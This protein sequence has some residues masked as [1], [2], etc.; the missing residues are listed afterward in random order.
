MQL[1]WVFHRK[2]FQ[3]HCVD[4]RKDDGVGTNADRKGQNRND[5]KCRTLSEL[6]A[7]IPQ[8]AANVPEYLA[9][10]EVHYLLIL[11]VRSFRSEVFEILVL[12]WAV[13]IWRAFF[14]TSA[15]HY[16]RCAKVRHSRPSR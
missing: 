6:T 1:L 7:C 13:N 16:E 10:M 15:S 2:H 11:F 14:K 5:S 4:L 3:H 9:Q 12:L 8:I